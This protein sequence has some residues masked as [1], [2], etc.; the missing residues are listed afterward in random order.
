MYRIFFEKRVLKFLEKHKKE[1]II[2][3]FKKSIEKLQQNPYKNNLDIKILKWFE[4]KYRLRIWDF[5]FI[6]EI[7]NE[8]IIIIFIYAWNRWDIY[9]NIS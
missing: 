8:E 9:K 7:D 6:Y 3:Q 4:W 1:K 5:R 2:I